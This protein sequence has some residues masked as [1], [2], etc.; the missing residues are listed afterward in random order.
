MK[1]KLLSVTLGSAIVLGGVGAAVA[2]TQ[3]GNG[4]DDLNLGQAKITLIQA[5]TTAEQKAGGRAAHA[6]LENENGRLVF[7]VEVMNSQQATDVKVDAISGQVLSA[8]ADKADAEHEGKGETND[9]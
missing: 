1:R 4:E 9:D 3:Q 5:I 6:G 7:G 2:S 8:Q